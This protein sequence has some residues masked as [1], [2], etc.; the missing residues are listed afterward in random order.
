MKTHQHPPNRRVL[1][2]AL[3]AM[4]TALMLVTGCAVDHTPPVP[5][6][7]SAV[8]PTLAG[9][10]ALH[11]SPTRSLLR[12][13]GCPRPNVP[14]KDPKALADVAEP[15]RS[16]VHTAIIDARAEGLS[17]YLVSG[18]RSDGQQWDLRHGRVPAGQECNPAYPGHPR[19]AIPGRS[20]HRNLS[21][22]ISAADMGGALGWL[23]TH[24][25]DYGIH[26]PVGGENWHIELTGHPPL[27]PIIPFYAP[28]ARWI[29]VQAGDTNATIRA[30]GGLDNEVT[31]P[32]LI[33]AHLGYRPGPV[34]GTYGAGS[35]AAMVRFKRQ[36]IAIQRATHQAVWPNAD[37]YIGPRTIAMLRWWN[38]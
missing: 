9:G 17:L 33:L 32:Q 31:E 2:T 12:T 7:A 6:P 29:P 18:G 20:N 13:A 10:V 28:V 16:I 3:V 23:H 5:T 8:A 37:P 36:V 25:A 30:R 21:P 1:R 26:F 27:R 15:L 22:K 24:A 35:Q 11:Q 4:A 34:D 38:R 19:T 14:P